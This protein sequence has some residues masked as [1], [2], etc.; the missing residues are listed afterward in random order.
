MKRAVVLSGGGSKGA[1]QIGVWKALR[2]LGKKYSIVTGTSIGAVN[3]IL[4]VQKEYHKAEYLWK[5]I[6]FSDLFDVKFDDVKTEL[7]IYKKFA[8]QF[9]KNGGISTKK[10]H[11]F[12]S[13][14][15]NE[16]KF[17]KSK[18]DYGIVTYSVSKMQ[19]KIVLKSESKEKLLDYVMASSACY[20]AFQ[21]IKIDNDKYVD[22]G[23]YDNL[24][25]N[26]AID[27]GAE[28]I[29]AID[30]GAIGRKKSVSKNNATI[31]SIVPKN[32]IGSF[33]M[34][35]KKT[36]RKS[37]IYGYNDTMKVFCKLDGDKYTYKK[38]NL[39]ANYRRNKDIYVNQIENVLT[40]Y[41][42]EIKIL[43]RIVDLRSI[44]DLYTKRN[45][46]NIKSNMNEII[47]YAGNMLGL[48]ST[49]I[50]N[51]KEYNKLL[52]IELLKREAFSRKYIKNYVKQKQIKKLLN[53][54]A[55]IRYIYNEIMS[56][57]DKQLEIYLLAGLFPK[58][59]LSAIYIS[60]I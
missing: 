33:L 29:I 20:P 60:I 37:M 38:G 31:I 5:N 35:D 48:D 59:F 2:K 14:S 9:I 8:E 13:K 19:P 28:E 7:D 30:L 16:K 12:I 26:L 46:K 3:G 55:I 24:P 18:V 41:K 32:D 17:Y 1:Y 23:Y 27:M 43:D 40:D 11:N 56:G 58:E 42:N 49:K 45:D 54:S 4:M 57:N 53:T 47:E 39:I 6:G 34:F 10:I 36:C 44:T 15:Y 50:Y 51:I 22:G 21:S 25:I 52:K